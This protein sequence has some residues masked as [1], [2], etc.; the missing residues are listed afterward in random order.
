[1]GKH[2]NRKQ[3]RDLEF[4]RAYEDDK[5]N[6]VYMDEVK[7]KKRPKVTLEPRNEKQRDLMISLIGDP[8]V[9]VTGPAGSG[10]TYVTAGQAAMELAEKRINKIVLSRPNVGTGK[11]LGAFPGTVEEKMAPWLMAIT[12]VLKQF[13]G[14]SMFE[15]AMKTGAIEIQPMETIRGRSYPN[16][17]V[18]FDEAQ[19]LT[20][21]ELKAIVTRQGENSTLVLMGDRTQRDT[22]ADGL[23]WLKDIAK[24]YNV[25]ASFHE[26]D[27]DDI[28]RSGMCKQ[29]VKAFEGEMN[30]NDSI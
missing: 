24:R 27:S 19:N 11:S 23:R 7:Q 20:Q 6:L 15:H 26:F 9:I 28:V 13:L 10:K 8:C 21:D 25:E 16:C 18:L 5:G 30:D 3:R 12:D 2:R 29:W 22:N 1:M 17:W 14:A 4:G